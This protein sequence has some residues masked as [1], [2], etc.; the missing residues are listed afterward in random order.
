M[1]RYTSASTRETVQRCSITPGD[2][3]CNG[4]ANVFARKEV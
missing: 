4:M 3:F 2:P 1:S